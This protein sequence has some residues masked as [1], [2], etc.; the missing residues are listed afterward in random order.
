MK[1]LVVILL[2]FSVV[3]Y[4]NNH[5]F[6]LKFNLS[7]TAINRALQQQYN[8]PNFT[9]TSG[10]Y[11]AYT[12][13][14]SITDY[15]AVFSTDHIKLYMAVKC[16]T[17][18]GNFDVV[19]QPTLAIPTSSIST[20][21]VKAVLTNL[22]NKVNELNI[23]EWLKSV[24]IGKYASLEP[25]VYPSKLLKNINNS[26]LFNSQRN[27]DVQNLDL[28]FQVLNN[29]LVLTVTTTVNASKPDFFVTAFKGN[30]NGQY[31]NIFEVL[32]NIKVEI[33]KIT[34]L[35]FGE[36]IIWQGEPNVICEKDQSKQIDMGEV[37]NF[38][39]GPLYIAKVL[40][41]TNETFYY[42]EYGAVHYS[43]STG[44][45]KSINN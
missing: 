33:K 8:L 27:V 37:S 14:L 45:S 35:T 36:T 16:T 7:G 9:T 41:K 44:A 18:V 25:W 22:P 31:Y 6:T 15:Y 43:Q 4:A 1:N 11:Q 17:N 20:D 10:S 38:D 28:G 24:L 21:Q 2:F 12:Y 34:L 32:S 19:L 5:T 42:R 23:P 40:Y 13:T 30:M 3:S 39:N 29:K 26:T